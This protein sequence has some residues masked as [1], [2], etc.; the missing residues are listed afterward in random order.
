MEKTWNRGKFSTKMTPELHQRLFQEVQKNPEHLKLCRPHLH[1]LRS[2]FMT[3]QYKK[4][5]SSGE[6][7]GQNHHWAKRKQRSYSQLLKLYKNVL[8]IIKTLG[9]IFCGL[10]KQIWWK[11]YLSI[12]LKWSE[13]DCIHHLTENTTPAG[14][15]S[16]KTK[17][18]SRSPVSVLCVN[19][20]TRG[21]SHKNQ[22]SWCA[23]ETP[24][25]LSMNNF[26]SYKH[27]LHLRIIQPTNSLRY[28]KTDIGA[29]NTPLAVKFFLNSHWQTP[30][31]W[32]LMKFT[33][34]VSSWRLW[35]P[36]RAVV[37]IQQ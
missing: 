16:K 36:A 18:E 9:K 20:Y 2:E 23:E 19:K 27:K 1:Q 11:V 35:T 26:T 3:E 10:T 30:S 8:M 7:Q 28:R 34:S 4:K 32:S 22:S 15:T 21:R 25:N 24:S 12:H 31:S 33:F 5:D 6:Y 37:V 17:E 14:I 13:V 29:E